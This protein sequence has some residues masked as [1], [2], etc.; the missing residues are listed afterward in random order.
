MKYPTKN[1]KVRLEEI[2]VVITFPDV[3]LEEILGLPPKRDLDFS[4]EL[5]PGAALVLKAPYRMIVP[6]LIEL[7]INL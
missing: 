1:G 7:K 3:I 2:E 5:I 4:I 6:K